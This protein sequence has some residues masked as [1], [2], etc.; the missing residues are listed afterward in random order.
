M[1][2]YKLIIGLAVAET[3]MQPSMRS[4]LMNKQQLYQNDFARFI[5]QFRIVDAN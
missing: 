1:H 4:A 3:D 5:V 2:T